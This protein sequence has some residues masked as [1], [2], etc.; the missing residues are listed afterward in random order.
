MTDGGD[1]HLN[2]YLG[3]ARRRWRWLVT[4]PIVS[5][6]LG[7]F[8]SVTRERVYEAETEVLILTDSSRSLFS[9]SPAIAERFGRN[10]VSELQFLSSE[11]FGE[12]VAPVDQRFEVDFDLV[13]TDAGA[14]AVDSDLIAFTVRGPEAAEAAAI[15][16]R[17]AETYISER[18]DRDVEANARNREQA[19]DR[20]VALV[21]ELRGAEDVARSEV[22]TGAI[23]ETRQELATSE[24]LETELNERNALAR[25][26]NHAAVPSAPSAPNVSRN[27]ILALV[28]GLVLGVGAAVSRDL[29][30]RKARDG[31][32]LAREL[33]V[34]WL[35]EIRDREGR[36]RVA[37]GGG[38]AEGDASDAFDPY[39]GVF[40]SIWLNN[41]DE[42]PRT[43]A[44]T[45]ERPT[46][47]RTT[48]AVKL[49]QLEASRGLDVLIVDADTLDPSLAGRL[50][51]QRPHIQ[52]GE[53]TKPS[54][55][56][57]GMID[58]QPGIAAGT[59]RTGTPRLDYAEVSGD[60]FEHGLRSGAFHALLEDI[61]LQYDLV[62]FAVP[63]V[64]GGGDPRPAA[65][66]VD[67]TILTYDPSV[68]RT[69]DVKNSI[70]SLREARVNVMGLVS[71]QDRRRSEDRHRSESAHV[72]RPYLSGIRAHRR[73]A[74]LFVLAV[75]VGSV[76]ALGQ[77][78]ATY[79][80]TAELLVAPV[81][82]ADASFTGLSVVKELG[83]PTR[84]IQ[85]AATL[86]EDRAIAEEAARRLGD[87]WTADRVRSAI[88][89]SP[90]GETN[91]LEVTASTNDADDA[92]AV[93]NEY[94]DTVVEVRDR[95]LRG[96]VDGII[97]RLRAELAAA[98]PDATRTRQGLEG[99]ISELERLRVDGDPTVSLAEPASTPSG[100][101][102]LP[103]GPILGF[104]LLAALVVAPGVAL[105]AEVAGPRRVWGDGDLVDVLDAPV[106]AH[107]PPDRP[108]RSR[109]GL[110][111]R[112]AGSA[113]RSRPRRDPRGPSAASGPAADGEPADTG[114]DGADR[115]D[116]DG[117]VDSSEGDAGSS[118][119]DGAAA[120]LDG[121]GT[122]GGPDGD[123]TAGGPD[124]DG[125]AGG[126]DGDGTAG[127]PDG[128][129][130]ARRRND[131]NDGA[132]RGGRG[133]TW[134]AYRRL[135]VL[136]DFAQPPLHTL[137]IVASLGDDGATTVVEHLAPELKSLGAAVTVVDLGDR[138]ETPELRPV[139][140]AERG[141]VLVDT[142]PL[143][144]CTEALRFAADVDAVIVVARQGRTTRADLASTRDLLATAGVP[145]TGSIL[146]DARK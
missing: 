109:W 119:G 22:L 93:A 35:G 47:G 127:G 88:G 106:L 21:E 83:N 25:I 8:F 12:S 117:V 54:A 67:A 51:L 118:E 57:P 61:R 18:H 42:A 63:A 26:L 55:D 138:A 60:R 123:G 14:D 135:A 70:E 34:P 1:L 110:R 86:V 6:A 17:Y 121:D 146:L 74:A 9:A 28:A 111:R 10:P 142:P 79:E 30:D 52:L 116:R 114:G 113:P 124:G 23:E 129:G 85:T 131:G 82:P 16:T 144:E 69:V 71:I 2:D 89:V 132:R 32:A 48:A 94:A 73:F 37:N 13:T 108:A 122:A 7:A 76:L 77:R 104:A 91:V 46:S 43:I 115:P 92:A 36:R 58:A 128:D 68:S 59:V 31:V 99:R 103:T 38:Y 44:I 62:V 137:M 15:A 53:A 143:L 20:L 126:P 33:D 100:S 136:V 120:G 78:K 19:S 141:Y 84:T 72:G 140:G 112:R 81:E 125:T 27:M 90:Q 98:P 107:I 134:A 41:P 29:F 11:E 64:H 75:L 105:L 45:S 4:V 3:I 139:T 49:A 65:G 96:E 101:T 39:R 133:D 87:P 102:S 56:A 97:D 66:A 50:G 80:A 130:A 145:P 5:L 24:Q 95:A 40:N